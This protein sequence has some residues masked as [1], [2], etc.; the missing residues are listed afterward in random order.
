M[1]RHK[2]LVEYKNILNADIWLT[3]EGD[4]QNLPQI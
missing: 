1:Q 4:L 3:G 2:S